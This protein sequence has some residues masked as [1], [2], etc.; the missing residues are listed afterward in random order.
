MLGLVDLIKP[1]SK[2]DFFFGR[3]ILARKWLVAKMIA[4]MTKIR[5]NENENFQTM[6][7]RDD[8]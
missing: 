4:K 1:D 3:C 6:A 5:Q 7:N 2:W 8:S